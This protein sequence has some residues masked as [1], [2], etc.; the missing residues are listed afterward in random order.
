MLGIRLWDL[1]GKRPQSRD[2]FPEGIDHRKID[3]SRSA[4]HQ[5]RKPPP[6]KSRRVFGFLEGASDGCA[7]SRLAPQRNGAHVSEE[8]KGENLF[9]GRM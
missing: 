7:G 8:G 3:T 5:L 9:A 1:K 6:E 4:V 2:F